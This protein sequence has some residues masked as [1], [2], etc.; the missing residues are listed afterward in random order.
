MQFWTT[1]AIAWRRGSGPGSGSP[2]RTE[3]RARAHGGVADLEAKDSRLGVL[4]LGR[5][6]DDGIEGLV[7][8]ALHEAGRR[9]VGARGLPLVPR[10]R[11][12]L[13]APPIEVELGMELE[14]AL[15]DRAELLAPEVPEVRGPEGLVAPR[16][17]EVAEGTEEVPVGELAAGEMGDRLALPEEAPQGREGE[18][19]TA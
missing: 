15:V 14:E 16:E 1:S 5:P 4:L 12:E 10:C 3:A 18:V 7:E 9:V 6:R 13:E 2:V 11:R 17:S 8:E 19:G